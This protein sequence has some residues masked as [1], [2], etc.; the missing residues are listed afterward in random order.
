[1]SIS[2][3]NEQES[4]LGNRGSAVRTSKDNPKVHKVPFS[5][6][7]KFKD[8]DKEKETKIDKN[9]AAI[10]TKDII[11]KKII[12]KEKTSRNSLYMTQISG[13]DGPEIEKNNINHQVT[14]TK[15]KIETANGI[16]P[17]S[18]EVVTMNGI[19]SDEKGTNDSFNNSFDNNSDSI[20]SSMDISIGPQRPSIVVVDNK[21][22]GSIQV[23]QV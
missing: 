20:D 2:E 1:M 6:F 3:E 17:N 10:E 9:G 7:K 22:H 12:T 4:Q 14:I 11:T 13:G 16:P 19:S 18:S 23:S 21:N 15:V 5:G 8:K